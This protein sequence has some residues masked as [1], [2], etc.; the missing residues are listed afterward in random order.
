VLSAQNELG[1][2]LGLSGCLAAALAFERGDYLRRAWSLVALCYLFLLIGDAS[3]EHRIAAAL[4]AH[5][6]NLVQGILAVLAN[7]ASVVG[8]WMLARAWSVAG[9]DEADDVRARRVRYALAALVSLG[10]TGWPLFHDLRDLLS[11][12]VD[13]LVSLAS[14]LGDAIGLALVAPVMHTALAMRGG[15]LRWPWAFLT[16]S[17]LA[18]ISYDAATAALGALHVTAGPGLVGGESLRAVANGFVLAAGLAQRMAVAPDE[19]PSALPP[20]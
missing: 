16:A 12:Q 11:G 5:E 9:L 19:R 10:L 7:L 8:T 20:T 17:G 6:I 15:L 13:A 14:D 4:S 3:G 1:K 18:W 2:F